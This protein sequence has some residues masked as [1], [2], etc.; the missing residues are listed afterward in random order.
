MKYFR[1]K[2]TGKYYLL[3][4]FCFLTFFFLRG[5]PVF[6]QN[7][8]YMNTHRIVFWNVENLFDTDD[9]PLKDDDAFTPGGENHWTRKRYLQKLTNIC[10]VVAATGVREAGKMEPPTIVGLAEIENDRVLR[11]LCKGTVLRKYGYR[12]VHYE[13][14]DERGIDN[15]LLY[16]EAYFKPFLTKAIGVGDSS[17]GLMTRDLLL[18]EGTIKRDAKATINHPG[19][20]DDTLIIIVCHL[21]SKRGG[22]TADIK[23]EHVARKLRETLDTLAVAHPEAAIVA[24]GDFNASPEERELAAV[25]A[26][27]FENLMK[28]M[29]TGTGSHKYQGKWA[30]LDQVIVS[31]GMLNGRCPIQVAGRKAMLFGNDFMLADDERHLGKVPLRTYQ[32]VKYLGGYSDHLPVGVDLLLR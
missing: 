14:P 4:G 6:C 10:R 12:Y 27:G 13:S 8:D 32:G 16:R 15:A 31:K 29:K 9:D 23:R 5:N 20:I 22:A 21:P 30:Y 2:N 28:Q 1:H 18:V 25:D 19:Y 17:L 11:D 3:C 26:K 24:M 7:I